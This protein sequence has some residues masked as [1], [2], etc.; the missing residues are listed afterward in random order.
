MQ[1]FFESCGHE[2]IDFD[3]YERRLQEFEERWLGKSEA[4][5]SEQQEPCLIGGDDDLVNL[6]G[7]LMDKCKPFQ[8]KPEKTLR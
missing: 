7:Q 4:A 1:G 5:Q 2:Q 6:V 8:K 3:K